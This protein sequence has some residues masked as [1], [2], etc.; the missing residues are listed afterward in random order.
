MTG[1]GRSLGTGRRCL[2]NLGDSWK[3][4]SITLGPIGIA[5]IS[6]ITGLADAYRRSLG[7]IDQLVSG[8]GDYSPSASRRDWFGVFDCGTVG[9]S[10]NEVIALS[11]DTEGLFFE[12]PRIP[13]RLSRPD[14]RQDTFWFAWSLS[15]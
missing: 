5:L 7:L 11:E 9:F 6:G 14:G 15:R 1:L 4:I 10:I 3:F 13:F 2:L 8:L 12:I